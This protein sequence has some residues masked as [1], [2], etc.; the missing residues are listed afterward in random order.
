MAVV[1]YLD[2]K[3]KPAGSLR[4]LV[5]DSP[6]DPFPPSPD[7]RILKTPIDSSHQGGQLALLELAAQNHS[8]GWQS[9]APGVWVPWSGAV[10]IPH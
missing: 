10:R 5:P 3:V 1:L 9:R 4:I 2:G 8:I 7:V 6:L